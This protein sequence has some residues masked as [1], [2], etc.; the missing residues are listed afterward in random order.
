MKYFSKIIPA[1]L[2]ALFI[3]QNFPVASAQDSGINNIALEKI[4]IRK[5]D[6]RKNFK[7]GEVIVK[8]K[9][10]KINLKKTVGKSRA[11]SFESKKGLQELDSVDDLN[12]KLFKSEK[13]TEELIEELK[14]DPEVEYVEANKLRQPLSF[15]N[16]PSFNFQWA[17]NNT[18]QTILTVTGIADA[19]LDASEAWDLESTSNQET[20]VAVIDTGARFSHEDLSANMWDGSTCKDEN[21]FNIP[22]GCPNH[23]WDFKDS[24]NIPDDSIFLYCNAEDAQGNC[25]SQEDISGHGTFISGIIAGIHNNAKGI[26]GISAHN[27]IKVMPIRFDLDTFSEIKAINFAKNNGAKVINASFGGSE[28]SQLEKDAIDSFPGIFVAA[29]GNDT[30]NNDLNQTS[31]FYPSDYTSS[32]IISVAATDQNDA[33]ASFSNFGNISVDIAAPGVN[34]ASTFK[35]S[36]NSYAYGSGTSFAAPYVA[37]SA[38]LLSSANPSMST[39]AVKN[40]VLTSGDSLATLAGKTVSGKRLNLNNAYQQ[41]IKISTPSASPAAGTYASAQTVTL[42]SVIPEAAIYYTA[43]GSIPTTSSTQYTS[44]ITVSHDQTIKAIAVKNGMTDSEIMTQTYVFFPASPVFRFWSNEKQGHFYTSSE[45]EKNQIIANDKSWKF[46]GAAYNAFSQNTS[47]LTAVY[48]FWSAQKQHHFYTAS[49]AEKQGIIDN[50]KS[51]NFEGVSYYAYMNEQ[52]GTTALYRFWSDQK[53]GHF[54]TTSVGEKDSIIANDKS[55]KFEGIA[56]YV[57]SN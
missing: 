35:N 32:N 11:R 38:A 20:I 5:S 22:G 46:E 43:D 6:S 40:N 45:A 31:H 56:Y 47:G 30:N 44:P 25:I 55:W 27:K 21:N 33:L 23:G 53:Q 2:I 36:D 29:A 7:E 18:A 13:G 26:S 15:P 41:S 17:L 52:S 14:T 28:F 16:D 54:Y 51:W 39:A 8:F 9:K 42:S 12:A 10:D 37:A 34:I 48:R 24:D 1:I 3:F 19:D 49:E 50:D 57:P 4:G